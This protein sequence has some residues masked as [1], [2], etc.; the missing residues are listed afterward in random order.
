MAETT[1]TQAG[2][3]LALP[4][5]LSG[6]KSFPQTTSPSEAKLGSGDKVAAS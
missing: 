3:D 6:A 5:G 1:G 4:E 2:K